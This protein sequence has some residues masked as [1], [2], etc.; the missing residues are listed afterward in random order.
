MHKFWYRLLT[1]WLVW[2]RIHPGGSASI[3]SAPFM[4]RISTRWYS[5][6]HAGS[7]WW[8]MCVKGIYEVLGMNV[9]IWEGW[10]PMYHCDQVRHILLWQRSHNQYWCNNAAGWLSKLICAN[11]GI[12]CVIWDSWNGDF[13]K[14]WRIR[15]C[16][17]N[18]FH[19]CWLITIRKK[20][21]NGVCTICWLAKWRVIHLCYNYWINAM[22]CDTNTLNHARK[23]VSMK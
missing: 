2:H 8:Q 23:T 14:S 16:V 3:D 1:I 6:Q 20:A 12:C 22:N 9:L 15:R 21:W 13:K 11:E 10:V 18:G 17:H 7:V 19:G 5:S 4:Q